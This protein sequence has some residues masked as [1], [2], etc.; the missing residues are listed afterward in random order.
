M[1]NIDVVMTID[2]HKETPLITRPTDKKI[3]ALAI[4][5]L[6]NRHVGYLK[7]E[8]KIPENNRVTSIVSP[9]FQNV[10]GTKNILD[11]TQSVLEL[12]NDDD[13]RLTVTTSPVGGRRKTRK[14]RKTRSRKY[15][16]MV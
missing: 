1:E 7:N 4:K 2:G 16:R 9:S 3:S 13:I 14:T 12:S 15:R 5:F 10:S 8:Q 6:I 11:L